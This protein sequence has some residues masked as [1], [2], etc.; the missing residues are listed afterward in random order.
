MARPR[1]LLATITGL[2]AATTAAA[3]AGPSVPP[4]PAAATAYPSERHAAKYKVFD[5]SGRQI[6]TA[7]W[8]WTPTGGNCCEVY[9][10]A[11]RKG[12]LLEYGGS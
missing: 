4:T 11:S 10:T 7:K 9:I 6:G 8:H 3:L 1:L 12:E 5:N 2:V